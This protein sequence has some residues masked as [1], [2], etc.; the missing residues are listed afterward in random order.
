MEPD[1]S[2]EPFLPFRPPEDREYGWISL[3]S[4]ERKPDGMPFL[5]SRFVVLPGRTSRRDQHEVEEMWVI[6]SG[7]GKLLLDSSEFEVKP[8]DVVHF[9]SKL[10]HQVVNQSSA[11]M[12]VISIWW[13]R[14]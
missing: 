11:Q 9:A 4:E 1:T 2:S 14:G 5:Y 3:F 6:L 7:T 13:Q 8:G 12:E 10:S